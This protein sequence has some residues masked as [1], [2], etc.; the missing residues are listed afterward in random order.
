LSRQV[1]SGDQVVFM[2]NGG[3]DNAPHRFVRQLAA[4]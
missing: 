4:Q 2:S 3:F 1:H